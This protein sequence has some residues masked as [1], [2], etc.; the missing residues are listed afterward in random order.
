MSTVRHWRRAA[1]LSNNDNKG[2][3]QLVLHTN[4][5]HQHDEDTMDIT[6]DNK[7]FATREI[8]CSNGLHVILCCFVTH[9]FTC[10]YF[11]W[12]GRKDNE[13]TT[14]KSDASELGLPTPKGASVAKVGAKIVNKSECVKRLGKLFAKTARFLTIKLTSYSNIWMFRH[15][16]Y[17][18]ILPI[19]RSSTNF[20]GHSL[21]RSIV[22]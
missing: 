20:Y 9:S 16:L 12:S 3:L 10:G 18:W 14:G 19:H 11:G 1:R 17:P 13:S 5:I 2:V 7:T 8:E 21:V 15:C 6:A 4:L 22:Q